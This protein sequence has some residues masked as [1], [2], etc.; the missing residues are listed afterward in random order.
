[1]AIIV[2]IIAFDSHTIRWNIQYTLCILYMT[3]VVHLAQPLFAV[4]PLYRTHIFQLSLS[5]YLPLRRTIRTRAAFVFVFR[6]S[7]DSQRDSIAHRPNSS[8]I[9]SSANH[10]VI[11]LNFVHWND[12]TPTYQYI[13]V[14]FPHDTESNR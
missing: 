11:Q 14:A 13:I 7:Y 5:M 3:S 9:N 1:M 6:F 2:L 8:R 10:A 12:T 4:R